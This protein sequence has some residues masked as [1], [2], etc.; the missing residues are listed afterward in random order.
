MCNITS[1]K[2]IFLYIIIFFTWRTKFGLLLFESPGRQ[3]IGGRIQRGVGSFQT[4]R[5]P[6]LPGSAA[7]GVV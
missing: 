1:N 2:R 7:P 5:N 3:S 6:S 4:G